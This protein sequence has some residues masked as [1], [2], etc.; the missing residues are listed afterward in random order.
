MPAVQNKKGRR[1]KVVTAKYSNEENRGNFINERV[2]LNM[3]IKGTM[4]QDL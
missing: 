4:F 1:F 3:V 2:A